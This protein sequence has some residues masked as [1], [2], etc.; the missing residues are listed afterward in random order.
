MN[1]KFSVYVVRYSQ[2]ED[3][4]GA[5]RNSAPCIDCYNKMVK[6]GVK[7]IVYSCQDGSIQKEKLEEYTPR[8]YTSGTKSI[9]NTYL[10][11]QERFNSCSYY[12]KKDKFA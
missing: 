4:S 1:T 2:F 8:K 11:D 9:F 5:L 10:K 6:L 12:V 7:W 3:G